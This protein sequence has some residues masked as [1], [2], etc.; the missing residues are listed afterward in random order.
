MNGMTVRECYHILNLSPG[1]SWS[2]VKAAFRRC[3]RQSHPDVARSSSRDFERISEAYMTLRDRFRSGERFEEERAGEKG[4]KIDLSWMWDPFVKASSWVSRTVEDVSRKRKEKKEERERTRR[5]EEAR[6]ARVLDDAISE[7][8]E[9]L[10][11]IL[12][13]VDRPGSVSDRGRL[14]KRLESS[15]PEVRSLAIGRLLPSIGSSEVSSAIERCIS[16]FG[17]DEEVIDGLATLKDP[18]GSLRY[19]M[20]GAPHFRS[21]TLGVARKY[22]KWIKSIPG[23]KSIYSGLPEPASSQVAGVLMAQWPQDLPLPPVSR[24]ES[25]LASKD[26]ALL[27][28]LLRQLYR[29]GCPDRLMLRIRAISEKSEDPAVKAWSRAIVCRSTVV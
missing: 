24:I 26:E 8:E 12:S 16:R 29:R 18:M 23:G 7:A 4:R 6:R 9:S 28:P 19:A 15:L 11:A 27:V 25:F 14:L 22:L 10:E 1:A 21:M 5:E 2:E 13:R 20:A 3:A 17:L